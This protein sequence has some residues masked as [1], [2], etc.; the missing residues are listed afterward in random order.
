MYIPYGYIRDVY[1]IWVNDTGSQ[2]YTGHYHNDRLHSFKS[3]LW[4]LACG[5]TADLSA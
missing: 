3:G 5:R 1:H 2:K 4:V